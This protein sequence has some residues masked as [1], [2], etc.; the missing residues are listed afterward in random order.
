MKP[1]TAPAMVTDDE[2]NRD[3][4]ETRTGSLNLARRVKALRRTANLT[5][6]EL[7]LRSKISVSALS[8]L[9]NGQLSP[10]YENIIRLARG[11]DVDIS[12]LFSD[13]VPTVVTGRRS[14]TRQGM[15]VRV[16]TVNYDYEMLCTD[17][18][19]KQMVPLLARVKAKEKKEFG[20]LIS[21]DG[22]EVIFVLSGRIVLY[23]EYY[24][25]CLM[26]AGDS[27]YFDSTMPHGCV[28]QGVEDAMLFWVCSSGTVSDLVRRTGEDELRQQGDEAG[29][30]SQ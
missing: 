10:T 24:E 17:L 8:K 13:D 3:L 20:P 21:H 18:A 27:A 25:P 4:P 11:L 30:K 22:E 14:I 9:E 2:K 5:L 15:G 28:A 26:E 16:E 1:S 19:R 12:A 23:T 29:S 7:S 6:K